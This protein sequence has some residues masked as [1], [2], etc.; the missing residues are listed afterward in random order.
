MSYASELRERY[1]QARKRMGMVPALPVVS[2]AIIGR[3]E[4]KIESSETI[5][6]NIL[7]SIATLMPVEPERTYRDEDEIF[8]D[9]NPITAKQIIMATADA[10]CVPVKELLGPRREYKLT[11]WRQVCFYLIVTLRPDLS[12]PFI[13][14]TVQRDHTTVMH[15][16]KK[17]S[18][19]ISKYSH[20]LT[21]IL[22][23][24]PL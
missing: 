11:A 9:Y 5:M 2:K 4:G 8:T 3:I 17:V 16:H 18:K 19:N 15:G 10:A 21:A 20:H 13:G 1:S 14:R 6:R 12:Y 24:L 23:R 7:P 22:D